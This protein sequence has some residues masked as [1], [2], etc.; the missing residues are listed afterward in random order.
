[1]RIIQLLPTISF[2]DAVGNDTLA[3]RAMIEEMGYETAIYAENI[4]S[5]LPKGTGIPF[6][7]FPQLSDED[8]LIYH[9]STGTE[10]NYKL[11]S[12]GG[13]KV[14]IYHNIT[15][16]EFFCGYSQAAEDLTRAG[17]DGIKFLADKIDYCIADSEFNKADL[18]RM[19]Y[20]CRID[21]CPILIPF[22]DYEK[23]PNRAV[24]ERYQGDGITNILFV[25]RIAPNKRQEDVIRAFYC[26]LKRYNEKAR[27]FLVGSWNGMELYYQRLVDYTK[28]LGI[29]DEVIFVGHIKFDEILAYYRL[30]DAFLCMSEHEGFCVP[31]VEAMYFNVPIVARACAA[32][33]DTLG[34]GGLLMEK[35]TPEQAALILHRLVSNNEIKVH[36][37]QKGQETLARYQ[38]DAVAGT[39]RTLLQKVMSQNFSKIIQITATISRGDAVSNDIMAFQRTLLDKQVQT[40]I[41]AETLPNGSGWE[42]IHALQSLPTLRKNDIAIYHHAT[43]S[44]I[45]DVFCRL[46]CR[47]VLVYHNVTPPHFFAPFDSNAEKACEWGLRSLR[48]M[49]GAVDYCI[50]DSEFNKADL[51]RAGYTCPID[52]CPILIPFSDY[53]QPADTHIQEKY[54]DGRTN[55]IFVGRVAPNK[56]F[57][58]VIAVFAAY[59]EQDKDAR[60][61]LVGSY[62]ENGKYYQFLQTRIKKLHVEDVVFTGHIHFSEIL[63]YYKIASAFVCMS[64]HEGFCVPLVEAMLFRVPIVAYASTA[65]PDTLGGSG[66]MVNDKAPQ[67]VAAEIHKLITDKAYREAIVCGQ[68]KRL[69]DFSYEKVSDTLQKILTAIGDSNER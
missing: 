37:R 47:K 33:P 41:Y 29:E 7:E 40:H 19:G 42:Q 17:L 34:A 61:F 22:S 28:L 21:V 25:G 65:I 14:M 50:A 30:A 18:Q 64:E 6:S 56:K 52:V 53:G 54:G 31:L 48:E 11:P 46:P 57:E 68:D 49:Q 23:S 39:L 60:L 4:D 15:P 26:Y 12:L 5:R 9:A 44:S 51:F 35:N 58:D 66:V 62:D 13:K 20:T 67:K 27:L 45:P 32:I 36:I 8:I 1:M 63:A 38:Y 16:P 55:I 69:E 10:L 24:I 2:G 3:I 43:G 59:K